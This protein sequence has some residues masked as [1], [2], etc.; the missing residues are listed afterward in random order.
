MGCH[1]ILPNY[2]I[3]DF[4]KNEWGVEME[5]L[6]PQPIRIINKKKYSFRT[7]KP[8]LLIKLKNITNLFKK[9]LKL[10]ISFFRKSKISDQITKTN[11]NKAFK[12]NKFKIALLNLLDIAQL[13]EVYEFRKTVFLYPKNGVGEIIEKAFKSI[14]N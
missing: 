1:L 11:S 2:K 4:L 8:I 5:I 6:N 9:V 13:K 3:Y 7:F 14:K 12:K 10:A